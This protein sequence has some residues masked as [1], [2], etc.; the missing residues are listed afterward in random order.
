ML[1]KILSIVLGILIIGFIAHQELRIRKLEDLSVQQH[2]FNVTLV[3][4]LA[5]STG[6]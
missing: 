1:K 3:Q 6:E 4:I 5:G 2:V